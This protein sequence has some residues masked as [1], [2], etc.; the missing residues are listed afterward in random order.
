MK[1]KVQHLF[2]LFY[3]VILT[4]SMCGINVVRLS[5]TLCNES[6][7]HL[8]IM[9]SE[10]SCPCN[11][12]CCECGHSHEHED[13]KESDF[14][15]VDHTFQV[16]YSSNITL[17][18]QPLF[19]ILATLLEPVSEDQITDWRIDYLFMPSPPDRDALCIYRC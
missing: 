6:Y 14:V 1:Q 17:F 11:G 2:I 8:E 12:D 7:V 9:P 5:C 19:T 13:H 10:T 16:K 15:Q 18:A 4:I 3:A